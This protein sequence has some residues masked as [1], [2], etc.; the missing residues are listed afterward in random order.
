MAK[1]SEIE[2][3]E[4]YLDSEI[5]YEQ[6]YGVEEEEFE[7]LFQE[8]KKTGHVT[9]RE[10]QVLDLRFGLS[11][12]KPKTIEEVS[13]IIGITKE[14]IRAKEFGALRKIFNNPKGQEFKEYGS[15]YMEKKK[16]L[17]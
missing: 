1:L 8:A 15:D 10:W 17:Y 12:G 16:G 4:E 14:V 13:K 5:P 2:L 11:S 3:G 9:D 7:R 6:H